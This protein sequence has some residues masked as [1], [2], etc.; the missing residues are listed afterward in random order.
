MSYG[1]GGPD[2]FRQSALYVT[3]ILQGGNPA[4]TPVEQPTRFELAIN[5]RTASAWDNRPR[6]V[7]IARRSSDRVRF[8]HFRCWHETDVGVATVDVCFLG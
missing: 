2:V 8:A 5:L 7:L 4:N 1:A 3:K 6:I